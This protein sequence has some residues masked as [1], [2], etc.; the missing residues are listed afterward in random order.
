VS[1]GG[2][3]DP[4]RSG[5]EQPVGRRPTDRSSQKAFVLHQHGEPARQ[6]L[7]QRGEAIGVEKADAGRCTVDD[8]A[9]PLLAPG[10]KVEEHT[11]GTE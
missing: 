6:P 8:A 9:G 7:E 1:E 11:E 10:E 5:V 3:E 4:Q 2:H